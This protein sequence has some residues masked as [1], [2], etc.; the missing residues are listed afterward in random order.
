MDSPSNALTNAFSHWSMRADT[1][2]PLAR[3]GIS[4]SVQDEVAARSHARAAQARDDGLLA[5]EIAPV[6][7]A[8]RRATTQ[9][10]H[11]E[12]IGPTAPSRPPPACGPPSPTTGLSPPAPPHR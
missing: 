10:E 5:Q 6:E 12:G 2:A 9:L 11:D 8:G 3:L 7:V 1:E 4:R